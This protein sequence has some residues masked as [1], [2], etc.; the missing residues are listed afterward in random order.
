MVAVGRILRP[1]GNRG[2]VVVLPE[3]DFA[4]KRFGTGETVFACRAETIE[5]LVVTTS[6]EHAGRW[7]VG[8]DGLGSI[9]DAVAWRGQELRVT[10]E[11][12]HTLG[13]G[14]F[15]VHDLVGCEVRTVSG[16]RVGLVERVDTATGVP[17][18]VVSGRGEVLVPFVDAIC[19]EVDPGSRRIVIDPPDGLIELNDPGKHSTWR[20][21]K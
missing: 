18:L 6:R 12:L 17:V 15:Y 13:P 21:V 19:R 20:G 4:E 2:Q 11:S 7:I 8:F 9:D 3:T 1:H 10:A 5:R 14:A 16:Q